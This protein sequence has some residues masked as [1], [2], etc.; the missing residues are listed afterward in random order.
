[1]AGVAHDASTEHLDEGGLPALLRLP[2]IPW[3]PSGTPA[4]ATPATAKTGQ[5]TGEKSA[6]RQQLLQPVLTANVD[7]WLTP[8]GAPPRRLGRPGAP[9][10]ASSLVLASA[11]PAAA[12]EAA[13]REIDSRGGTAL[14]LCG[15]T[16][17]TASRR[18]QCRS[19]SGGVRRAPLPRVA[20]R[21]RPRTLKALPD[22]DQSQTSSEWNYKLRAP[23]AT[24]VT[25]ALYARTVCGRGNVFRSGL[26]FEVEVHDAEEAAMA[27]F[28]KECARH[29]QHWSRDQ[30]AQYRESKYRQESLF[31][32]R[33]ALQQHGELS[34]PL[35]EDDRAFTITDVVGGALEEATCVP[36]PP[37]SSPSGEAL[38]VRPSMRRTKTFRLRS[39]ENDESNSDSDNEITPAKEGVALGR[40]NLKLTSLR[41][42]QPL[43]ARM[44]RIRQ[45]ARERF[46]QR[47]QAALE[48]DEDS[49]G[50]GE[51]E[52]GESDDEFEVKPRRMGRATSGRTI[53]Q[54]RAS[55]LADFLTQSEQDQ[56]AFHRIFEITTR[57]AANRLTRQS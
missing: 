16:R 46:M 15:V 2:P 42:K 50:S 44:R 4:V 27:Y 32:L 14:S 8:R 37:R 3:T 36:P 22:G 10:D 20:S 49:K 19:A 28:R 52:E 29:A 26:D 30:A 33:W 17:D 53:V 5:A 41:P 57:M 7:R 6:W 21:R 45:N 43:K 39:S 11:C 24:D 34:A 12:S 40:A 13:A 51:L 54:H 9:A 48:N 31:E 47:M 23:S 1:M 38:R 56:K 55:E 25:D 18:Q 35:V